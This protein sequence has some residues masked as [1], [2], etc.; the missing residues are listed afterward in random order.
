MQALMDDVAR[1]RWRAPNRDKRKIDQFLKVG[2]LVPARALR[3]PIE[4]EREL[5]VTGVNGVTAILRGLG[6]L[7]CDV[8]S[9]DMRNIDR[10][11]MVADA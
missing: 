5:E 9:V 6:L 7:G 4:S 1:G 11:K 10:D 2:D 8:I 3:L